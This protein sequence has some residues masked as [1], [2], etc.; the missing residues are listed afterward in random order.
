MKDP[1]KD[2]DY[3]LRLI[4]QNKYKELRREFDLDDLK[5]LR[6]LEMINMDKHLQLVFMMVLDEQDAK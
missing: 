1:N 3:A 5:I 2:Y 6:E 4:K